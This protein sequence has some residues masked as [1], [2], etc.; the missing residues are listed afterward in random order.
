MVFMNYLWVIKKPDPKQIQNLSR[1][2]QCTEATAAILLNRN[3]AGL[4]DIDS[5]LNP[6]LADL[7]PPDLVKDMDIA[8]ERLEKALK[9]RE[10]IL[11][12]GDYDADGITSTALLHSFLTY[13]GANPDYYIPHRISEGYSLK[14]EHIDILAK[15][16][17]PDLIVTV[18]CGSS[19][20]EAVT[21][22]KSR[23][24]DVIVTD[25]H[26][27]S[28]IPSDA[29][30][31]INPKRP[32]CS[33]GL[34][35]LAGVGV[36][37]YLA[38]ALRSK[39]RKSGFWEKIDEPNLKSYLDLVA[40]GTIADL[41]PL[42]FENRIFTSAGIEVINSGKNKGIKALATVAGSFHSLTAGDIS[43]RIAPRLNAAGRME[44]ASIG[45]DL[46]LSNC[47][48]RA[49]SI[50]KELNRLNTTRQEVENHIFADICHDID[51]GRCC[52][53][54][55]SIVMGSETW[56]LGVL[57]IVASKLVQ[58]YNKPA[59]LIAWKGD[60]GKASARTAQDIDLY[61]AIKKCS[62]LIDT[63]GGHAQAAGLSIDK[64]QMYRFSAMFD[65]AVIE[66][67]RV[68]GSRPKE[69]NIDYEL[70]F[71][72][73]NERL[74]DELERLEPFGAS[75]DQP[76]FITKNVKLC[77]N[78]ASSKNYKRMMAVQTGRHSKMINAVMFASACPSGEPPA[79]CRQIAFK[80]AWNQYGGTKKPQITI[81]AFS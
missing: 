46:L 47:P 70:N 44:H 63:F 12:F 49:A 54:T 45:L 4:K 9:N 17:S 14:P 38:I 16:Y 79:F 73:I 28:D 80:L 10:K 23:G 71:E 21:L 39:L 58:K 41:A 8:V 76:L 61:D 56:H 20:S 64:K 75:N 11:I 37:F 52:T 6:S 22:A 74:L 36:A 30:A 33:S 69:L 29:V 19:S 60:K 78:S 43:Y 5:F 3:L 13:T 53:G 50:A 24:I 27:I 65:E 25:H 59:V 68:K 55:S 40:I 67:L 31:V 48:E 1:I 7:R 66:Q 77:N 18:D 35:N 26:I 15:R 57:G 72:D 32:D 34:D 2:L 62:G 51:N 42:T 81:E